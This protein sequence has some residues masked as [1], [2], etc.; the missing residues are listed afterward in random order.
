MKRDSAPATALEVVLS[1][2]TLIRLPGEL[3]AS[4]DT[5]G[6]MT[7]V[8]Q[9]T[10]LPLVEVALLWG[11]TGA[12]GER[13]TLSVAFRIGGLAN[14]LSAVGSVTVAAGEA[15]GVVFGTNQG[16]MVRTTTVASLR[17]YQVGDEARDF[18][19]ANDQRSRDKDRVGLDKSRHL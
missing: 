4:N 8:T 5:T 2:N 13:S 9:N 1:I 3:R 19:R 18:R 16:R 17:R 12:V 11:L 15:T 6:G 14:T 10:P 7:L